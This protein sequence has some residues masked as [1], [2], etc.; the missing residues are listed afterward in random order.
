MTAV[1][2]PL[3]TGPFVAYSAPARQSKARRIAS[4][5]TPWNR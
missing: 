1:R 4:R 2:P 3:Q 5:D